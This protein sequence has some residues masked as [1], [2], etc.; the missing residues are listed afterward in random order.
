[1]KK[2]KKISPLNLIGTNV[3][4]WIYEAP[5]ISCYFVAFDPVDITLEVNELAGCFGG[6]APL[7]LL[8]GKSREQRCSYIVLSII[9]I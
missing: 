8:L 4:V 3:R 7:L 9:A 1:V 5:Y 6:Y 2:T